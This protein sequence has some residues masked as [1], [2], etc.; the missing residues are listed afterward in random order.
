MRRA[1][2][3]RRI[4][5]NRNTVLTGDWSGEDIV[6]SLRVWADALEITDPNYTAWLGLIG[7]SGTKANGDKVIEY[8]AI[9]ELANKQVM[10]SVRKVSV[11][12]IVTKALIDA[13]AGGYISPYLQESAAAHAEITEEMKSLGSYRTSRESKFS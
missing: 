2:Q 1:E 6:A 13:A 5:I 8:F 12:R 4:A 7:F 10:D 11:A 9:V 3:A